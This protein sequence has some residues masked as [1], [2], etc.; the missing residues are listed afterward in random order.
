MSKL[1]KAFFYPEGTKLHREYIIK[2]KLFVNH[3]LLVA[4]ALFRYF[5]ADLSFFIFEQ[6]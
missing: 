1:L 4:I 3:G 2:D 6:I 5:L